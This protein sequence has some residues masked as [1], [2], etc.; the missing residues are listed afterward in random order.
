MHC[1]PYDDKWWGNEMGFKEGEYCP[2]CDFANWEG[3]CPHCS[4][5]GFLD[6]REPEQEQENEQ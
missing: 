4:G 1:E 3:I 6:E 5:E 2:N